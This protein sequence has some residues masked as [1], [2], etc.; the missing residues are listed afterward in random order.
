[1]I[2]AN[3]VLDFWFNELSPSQHWAKD[4]SLDRNI[5][6]RFS[7]LVAQASK[8][9]LHPWRGNSE[10]DPLQNALGRLAEIILLDQFSRNIF[11][12]TPESFSNDTLALCLAQEAVELGCLERLTP[13]QQPFLIMP[14]MHSESPL[15]H[16]QAEALFRELGNENSLNFELKHKAIIDTFGRYPHRNKILGRASTQAEKDFLQQPGSSF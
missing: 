16:K 13:Q 14:Y 7:D 10:C 9:E 11:R 8:N 6:Q 15:I 2:T 12:D 5:K 4:A 3:D 1:M